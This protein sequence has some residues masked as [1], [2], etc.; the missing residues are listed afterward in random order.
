GRLVEMLRDEPVDHSVL[1]LYF[2]TLSVDARR[3][4]ANLFRSGP[5]RPTTIVIDTAAFGYLL[6]Q[7]TPRRDTAMAITLPFASS[8]PFTPDVA[9]LVPVEMFHG[10][11]E[12]LDQVVN[13]MG[14]CIIYGGRQLGKSALLR[15]AARKFNDAE[16]RV[17]IYQSIYKVGQ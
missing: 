5:R 17:A 4:L 16:Q 11:T 12:E 9:G 6:A 13:M 8:A 7:P 1:V 10:R 2:G 14:S 3:E 15:A